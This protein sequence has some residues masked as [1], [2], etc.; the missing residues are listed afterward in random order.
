VAALT[1]DIRVRLLQVSS[2][3]YSAMS[4][5]C[6][7]VVIANQLAGAFASWVP[8]GRFWLRVEQQTFINSPLELLGRLRAM[9]LAE[10]AERRARMLR[11]VADVQ[12]N[13]SLEDSTHAAASR[14]TPP[15]AA[16][17]RTASRL[18][19]N[20]LRA[21]SESCLHGASTSMLGIYPKAHPYAADDHW[22]LNCSCLLNPP[23]FWWGP[24]T[25]HSAASRAKLWTRGRVP[26]ETCRCLHCSTLCPTDEETELA[27]ETRKAKQRP[28]AARIAGRVSGLRI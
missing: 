18:A 2:R 16:L 19:S 21:A 27:V 12:Y 1:C 20:F 28:G 15:S 25:G 8:Y 9:P 7:P 24:Q 14:S 17:A 22:G 11:H 23:R 26:T 5:G 3:L 13:Q 10:V 6:I 4:A